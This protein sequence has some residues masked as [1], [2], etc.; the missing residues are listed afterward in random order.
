MFYKCWVQAITSNLPAI[1][2]NATLGV[3]KKRNDDIFLKVWPIWYR[4]RPV[5]QSID[6][7]PE[8]SQ[9]PNQYDT[10]FHHIIFIFLLQSAL[11]T[12]YYLSDEDA[13]LA[14][15]LQRNRSCVSPNDI[16]AQMTYVLLTTEIIREIHRPHILQVHYLFFFLK[17][18]YAIDHY[19]QT[20]HPYKIKYCL[21]QVA[22][23]DAVTILNACASTN[24]Q[25]QPNSAILHILTLQDIR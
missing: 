10:V 17:K 14:T 18:K 23:P 8:I 7:T 1:P 19:T 20:N 22:Y 11:I 21:H 6:A 3:K 24:I 16:C 15:I 4:I 13:T 25:V 9:G 2:T 12:Y 5:C